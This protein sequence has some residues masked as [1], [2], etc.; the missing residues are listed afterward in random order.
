[1]WKCKYCEK[2]N[3]DDQV[4]CPYCNAPNPAKPAKKEQPQAGSPVQPP[5]SDPKQAPLDWEKRYNSDN[6][7]K[8]KRP[9]KLDVI[10]KYTVIGAVA[11]L[12]IFLVT[13]MIQKRAESKAV[14]SGAQAVGAEALE[15]NEQS[16]GHGHTR[17]C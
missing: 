5:Q 13:V 7:G 17:R 16:E 14:S 11:L 12:M 4:I 1:M 9:A 8:T 6:R 2:T 10:L 3:F 15:L